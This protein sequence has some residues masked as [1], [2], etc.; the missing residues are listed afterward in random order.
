M[1]YKVDENFL[2]MTK[3]GKE[4]DK[5]PGKWVAIDQGKLIA[6]ADTL[7]EL[8]QKTEVKN[9]EHPLYHFVPEEG[10]VLYIF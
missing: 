7:K 5:Y 9:A 10:D 8:E 1:T 2:W 4:L 6:V 3:H